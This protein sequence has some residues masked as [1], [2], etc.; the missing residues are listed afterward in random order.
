MNRRGFGGHPDFLSLIAVLAILAAILFPLFSWL[1]EEG[2]GWTIWVI[3]GACGLVW[4]CSFVY[5]KAFNK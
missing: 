1:R 5:N 3:F 4:L 2:Y